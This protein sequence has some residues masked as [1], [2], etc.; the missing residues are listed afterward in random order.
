MHRILRLSAIALVAG[1][2]SAN[3]SG[4]P[5]ADVMQT[6]RVSTGS[7]G[8]MIASTV[9]STASNIATVNIPV[10]VAWAVLPWVYDSLGIKV[11]V[12]DQASHVFGNRTLKLRRQL[13][14]IALS[15]YINCGNA[16]GGPSADTYEVQASILTQLLPDTTGGT[17]VV[18]TVET[19][20]RPVMLSGDY[21]NCS[22]KGLLEQRIVEL[23][24]ARA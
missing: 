2:A 11:S 13:G 22:S 3:G 10:N 14:T 21:A 4:T 12:A 23:I 1:C 18:T 20:G 16:Q 5:A 15:K 24:K 7:G 8:S 19:S 17:R 9:A 6:V